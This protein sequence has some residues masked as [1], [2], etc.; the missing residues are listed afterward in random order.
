M[1]GNGTVQTDNLFLVTQFTVPPPPLGMVERARVSRLLR[2]GIAQPVTLLCAPAGSGKTSLLT[3]VLGDDAPMPVAWLSLE[4]GDDVPERFWRAVVTALCRTG[5]VPQDS[6]LETLPPAVRES[7]D[8]FPSLLVNA[9][10]ELPERVVLVLD[11]VHLIR[12]RE[13]LR[14][15]A[16]LLL[17]APPT[18]AVVL[19]SRADPVLPLPALRVRGGFAEIRAHDL[20]FTTEEAAALL[21]AHGVELAGPLVSAL[22]ARTEGWAA[23]L[24][25]AAL[26]LREHDEPA[27]YVSDFA[28]SDTAVGDYLVAEVLEHQPPR[29]RRFLLQTSILDQLSGE[30]ADA[31]TGDGRGADTLALLERTNGFV[32]P[33]DPRREWFRY[34]RLFAT[35]LRARAMRELGDEMVELHRRAARCYARRGMCTQALQH[36]IAGGD[37]D[38]GLEVICAHWFEL[39]ARGRGEDIRSL[40][41]RLPKDRLRAYPELVGILASTAFEAGDTDAGTEHLTQAVAATDRVDGAKR[42]RLLATIAVGELCAARVAA[43]FDRAVVVAR[44]GLRN[45][46]GQRQ[47]FVHARLGETALWS[48]RLGRA[49]EALRQAIALARDARLDH[50]LI[51]ALGHL[52]LRDALMDE[53]AAVRRHADEA[54]SL[55]NSPGCSAGPHTAAAH[56]ALAFTA[57]SEMR[58]GEAAE[59]LE[60]AASARDQIRTRGFDLL[61]TY[62]E[63]ELHGTHGRPDAGLG[64]LDRFE[65]SAAAGAP[66]P[67]ERAALGCLRARLCAAAGDLDAAQRALDAVAGERWLMVEVVRARLLL[68]A[69]EPDAAVETLE[70]ATAPAMLARTHVERA[71]LYAVALDQ[72]HE[73]ERAAAVLEEALDLAEPSGQRWAFLTVGGRTEPLLRDQIRRGTSHRAFVGELLDSFVD[74][75]RPRK[76][77]TP[78]LE[79]L[80]RREQAILRYLPTSLSNR[81]MAAELFISSNTVKTHLRNIPPKLD[82]ERR[83][84]AVARAR[85]LSLLTTSHH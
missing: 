53:T 25:L 16:F 37:A 33:L 57:L 36:A 14:Q 31:V 7:V 1:S 24:R 54:L 76:T 30:L 49:A 4:P 69:G 5:S 67:Y 18:L 28:G 9:L 19:S 40:V 22:C 26:G 27:R 3:S 10:A 12:S 59:H 73:P 60:R 64:A 65:L 70:G 39:L 78:L 77:T 43:D 61:L 51:A 8:G 55:A 15:L 11:D 56:L 62:S 58:P 34:H 63:A 82:V 85:D 38:L 21:S 81:E 66:S 79:P 48:H 50:L 13:C 68:A 71:V 41:E 80:T 35:L 6:D 74:P 46:D 44:D 29:L 23:G 84:D 42:R 2:S 32:L 75:D 47:A 72:A 17:H 52:A 20:A 45:T 83:R